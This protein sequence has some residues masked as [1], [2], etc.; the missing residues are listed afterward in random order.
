MTVGET[1]QLEH[2]ITV[3]LKGSTLSFECSFF[4]LCGVC[5]AA[6]SAVKEAKPNQDFT[7]TLYE[8]DRLRSHEVSPARTQ[9]FFLKHKVN[10]TQGAGGKGQT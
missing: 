4:Q 2:I 5:L 1:W 6:F 10:F 9:D 8:T 7:T 3:W